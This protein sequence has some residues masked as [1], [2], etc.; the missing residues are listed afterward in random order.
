MQGVTTQ[1]SAPKS[2]TTYITALKKKLD[3]RGASPYLLRMHDIL[4]QTFF[5][6]AKFLTT[7]NQSSSV[8]EINLSQVFDGG[9]LTSF[10]S[11]ANNRRLFRS[12]PRLHC[13]VNLCVPFR[14]FHGTSM[15][16]MGHRGWGRFPSSRITTVFLTCQYQK[17]TFISVRVY[18]W[19]LHLLTGQGLGPA[20]VGNAIM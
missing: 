13:A 8:T 20:L 16:H 19:T 5:S 6:R 14:A 10:S 3:T 7:A 17:C 11:S 1:V 2:S 15:S 12:S 9:F 18:A 4:L